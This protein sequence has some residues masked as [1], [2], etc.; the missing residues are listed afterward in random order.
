MNATTLR[1]IYKYAE[2]IVDLVDI[3]DQ[4][5][6]LAGAARTPWAYLSGEERDEFLAACYRIKKAVEQL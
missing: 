6:G 4:R 1:R 2:R 3:A 5:A